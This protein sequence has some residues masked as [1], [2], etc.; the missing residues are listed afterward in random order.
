MK[1]PFLFSLVFGVLIFIFLQVILPEHITATVLELL[2]SHTLEFLCLGILFALVSMSLG[3][4]YRMRQLNK[5]PKIDLVAFRRTI[6]DLQS[7][8]GE[9]EIEVVYINLLGSLGSGDPGKSEFSQD[10]YYAYQ[11][12][13]RDVNNE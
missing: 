9:V 6:Q 1:R 13:L 7:Y 3:F 5:R 8:R 12:N 11:R 4:V 10:V 2:F